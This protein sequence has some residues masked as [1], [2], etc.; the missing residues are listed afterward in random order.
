MVEH[1][2]R[3]I[4]SFGEETGKEGAEV[5]G[6]EGDA[7]PFHLVEIEPDPKGMGRAGSELGVEEGRK[8]GGVR[9][10]VGPRGAEEAVEIE[11]EEWICGRGDERGCSA[12]G[13]GGRGGPEG[14]EGVGEIGVVCIL[15][16]ER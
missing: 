4:A 7:V 13:D 1:G 10:E 11:G 6:G 9:A 15:G 5:G 12:G 8:E 14:V 3:K 2:A 16:R